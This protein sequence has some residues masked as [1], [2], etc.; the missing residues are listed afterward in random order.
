VFIAGNFLTNFVLSMTGTDY[1]FCSLSFLHT[2]SPPSDSKSQPIN[3][4]A[5]SHDD[6]AAIQ[7]AIQDSGSSSRLQEEEAELDRKL[8]E[9]PVPEDLEGQYRRVEVRRKKVEKMELNFNLAIESHKAKVQTA[10]NLSRLLILETYKRINIVSA[11]LSLAPVTVPDVDPIVS[12][13]FQDPAVTLQQFERTLKGL[14]VLQKK[15]K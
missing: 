9:L 10:I 14:P 6:L 4:E 11:A 7:A 2:Y 3:I 12:N 1:P 13:G 5:P 15:K 8:A